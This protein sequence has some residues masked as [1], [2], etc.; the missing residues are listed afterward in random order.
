MLYFSPHFVIF[1][2]LFFPARGFFSLPRMVVGGPRSM[3]HRMVSIVEHFVPS[4]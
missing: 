4:L 2:Y 1:V 3:V